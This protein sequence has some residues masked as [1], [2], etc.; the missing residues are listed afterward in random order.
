MEFAD[1]MKKAKEAADKGG[2]FTEQDPG[3]YIMKLTG[4]FRNRSQKGEGRNQ[5]N[6]DWVIMEPAEKRDDTYR[7]YH[8]LDHD[9]G[10]QIFVADF[11]KMGIDVSPAGSLEELDPYLA[12]AAEMQPV[13]EVTLVKKGEYLNTRLTSYI[14]TGVDDSPQKAEPTPATKEEVPETAQ[15]SL[16]VGNKI[17]YQVKDKIFTQAISAINQEKDTVDTAFH[18]N[19]SLEDILELID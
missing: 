8:N 16:K 5:T 17:K 10:L 13:F 14:G 12:Q 6:L 9:I 11:A 2:D 15:V 19:I 18:K 7:S 3:K 4:C 1:M